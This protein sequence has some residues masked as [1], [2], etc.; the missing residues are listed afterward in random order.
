MAS[1]G[2]LSVIAMPYRSSGNG[3]KKSS[4]KSISSG[5]ASM[6]GRCGAQR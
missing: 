6:Y 1:P 4:K 3:P 5:M 2:A